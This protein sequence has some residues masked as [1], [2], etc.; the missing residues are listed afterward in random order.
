MWVTFDAAVKGPPIWTPG[1]EA[2]PPD[3]DPSRAGAG[4]QEPEPESELG[5]DGGVPSMLQLVVV[6]DG[7]AQVWAGGRPWYRRVACVMP[8]QNL[9]LHRNPHPMN[10]KPAA[11]CGAAACCGGAACCCGGGACWAG[12]ACGA[13]PPVMICVSA[14][15]ISFS[16]C[17]MI[18]N[19]PI[20][21]MKYGI[22]KSMMSFLQASSITRSGCT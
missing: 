22:A 8:Y 12:A 15:A 18:L 5:A 3:R 11:S 19:S 20:T 17:R 7:G 16:W 6:G 13:A 1:E 21:W 4:Q 2:T 10:P 9:F 14:T